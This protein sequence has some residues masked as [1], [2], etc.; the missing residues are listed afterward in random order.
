MQER[1]QLVY[2]WAS[3]NAL[4]IAIAMAGG[5]GKD[6]GLTVDIHAQTILSALCLDQSPNHNAR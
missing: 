3:T 4:P 6:I 5:Y 1:D 2:H